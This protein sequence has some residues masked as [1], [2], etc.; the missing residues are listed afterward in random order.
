MSVLAI[1][2]G[3]PLRQKNF[4]GWPLV[5]QAGMEEAL[6]RVLRSDKW[7]SLH[8][9]ETRSFEQEY[10]QYH[11]AKYGVACSNGT[12]ALRL[13]LS[14]LGIGPGDEVIVPAYTFVAS[15]VTVL[16][17]RAIPVFVDIDPETYTL[18]PRAVEAAITPKT[19]AIMPVHIAGRPADMDAMMD[20]AARHDL[21]VVEDAAQAWGASYK[22]R[23]V[24]AIG[25]CGCFSFQSSKNITSAEGGIILTNQAELADELASWAN[26]GR[27]KGGLWYAHYLPAGNQ[28]L[29]EFQSALL[30]EQMKSYPLQLE[31]RRRNA[32]ILEHKLAELPGI[33]LIPSSD[34]YQG[35][36]HL[37]IIRY[38]K[39][40]FRD[41]PKDQFI[42]ALKAEG[43]MLHGG[44]SLPLYRQP[45]FEESIYFPHQ[46]PIQCPF[47]HNPPDYR[48]LNLPNT[49]RA[50][51]D[52]AIWIPQSIF[53]G[54]ADDMTDIAAAFEKVCV[55]HQEL[56][57]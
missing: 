41:I 49:E 30:R 53:L 34:D 6:L 7:G 28:R 47:T 18:D 51:R 3:T 40:F 52:E 17:V 14:A 29:T 38:Q 44:Y 2:G 50:C 31:H 46:C 22:G 26:C 57:N 27:K 1:K 45:V 36:I 39:E 8:G 4:P 48:S 11:D 21:K 33:K 24:G 35:S 42:Q 55:N 32:R 54:T 43:L 56:L 16:E 20:I 25:D 5:D 13:A 9:N 23:K 10:A 15:A 37:F 19:K 12:V